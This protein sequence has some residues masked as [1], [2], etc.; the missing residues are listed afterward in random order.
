MRK[1]GTKV[2]KKNT[3]KSVVVKK[4]QG[5][6]KKSGVS[7]KSKSIKKASFDSFLKNKGPGPQKVDLKNFL[8]EFDRL[9][10]EGDF[11]TPQQMLDG[12][13]GLKKWQML[14]NFRK[15]I[16]FLFYFFF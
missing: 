4:N 5:N 6:K 8:K 7:N 11:E 10:N 14:K 1:T 3:E 9:C 2:I 16:Q 12:L 15:I 13:N